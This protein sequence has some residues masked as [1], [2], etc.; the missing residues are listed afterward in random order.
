MRSFIL[1]ASPLLLG[2]CIAKTAY[3]V[4]TLPVRVVSAGVDAVTTSQSEADQRRGRQIRKEDER[5]GR[6][7]RRCAR[8]PEREQCAELRERGIL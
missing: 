5:L 6:L 7:A 8:N 3:D 2:G 4:A 1:L